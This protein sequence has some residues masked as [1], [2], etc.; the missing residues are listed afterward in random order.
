MNEFETQ[1][2]QVLRKHGNFELVFND[3]SV[4]SAEILKRSL[5]ENAMFKNLGSPYL[6]PTGQQKKTEFG[7]FSPNKADWRIECKSRH[8]NYG[9]VGEIE[10]DLNFVADIPEE[11]FCLVL[12]DNL[13]N[14]YVMGEI[15][16]I[17][18]DKQI[19]D[20]VWIGSK[21]DFKK[22]LKKVVN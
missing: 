20:K 18:A 17:I 9:L 15:R 8:N 1:I 6:T 14:P 16:Q 19:G 4:R 22:M 2:E 11:R 13:I 3:E 12:T 5:T 21:K 10:R 7:F